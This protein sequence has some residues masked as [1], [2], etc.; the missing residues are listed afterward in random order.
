MFFNTTVW[1]NVVALLIAATVSGTDTL[2]ALLESP[3]R[4]PWTTS[5][6]QG[7]PE[8][9]FPFVLERLFPNLSF[10]NPVTIDPLPNSHRLVVC[11]HGG[12]I[13]SFLDDVAGAPAELM[14][15]FSVDIP[16]H[17]GHKPGTIPKLNL[18]SI[19]F[20]PQFS[21]NRLAYVC[22]VRGEEKIT[23]D[24]TRISSFRVTDSNPP[25]L[26]MESERLIYTCDAGGHNGCTL[27]FGN[28]G[29][30][31]ISMGD[32]TDPSPPDSLKTGQDLT[33]VYGS[34]LRIDVDG[35]VSGIKQGKDDSTDAGPL[36]R[37]PADNPF[38]GREG[39][40]PEIYAYGFRNPWR[41]SFDRPTGDLWVGDVGWESWEMV[42]RVTAGGN[43]GWSVMEGPLELQPDLPRGPTP[44]LPPDV[45]L[46]HSEAASVT[47]GYVYRGERLPSLR[48]KY[49][50]GDWM[51]RKFWS[52][53]FDRQRVLALEEIAVGNVKPIS[54]GL[55]RTGELLIM[56]Y[57][58]EPVGI[59]RLVENPQQKMV[60]EKPFPRRLSQ[61]GLFADVNRQV[62]AEGVVGYSLNLPMWQ[63]GARSEYFLA[64][65]G[66]GSARVFEQPQ[67][68]VDWFSTR[69]KFP[70]G[71]VLV[72]TISLGDKAHV[73]RV[74]TQ[75][76]V[77]GGVADW[78]FYTYRWNEE[79]TDA[80]LVPALG[81]TIEINSAQLSPTE[82]ISWEFASRSQCRICH[83]PWSGESLGM[84]DWQLRKPQAADD[85]YR[86][87]LRD[88]VLI[89]GDDGWSEVTA[90]Q[91]F[92]APDDVSAC[93]DQR[94][95]SYLHVNCSHCHLMG[96][97]ASTV[98]D[99]RYDKTLAE[100]KMVNV[101]PMKGDYHLP[102]AKIIA[103][104]NPAASVL[105]YRLAKAG[106][107]RMPHIGSKTLD[108]T[109][110][111][112][113]WKWIATL[114]ADD[115]V[116]DALETLRTSSNQRQRRT[117]AEK[118]MA[119]NQG[120]A[121]LAG[122]LADGTLPPAVVEMVVDLSLS[123][124]DSIRELLEPYA[125]PDQRVPRLGANFDAEK[126]LQIPGDPRRGETLF[127]DGVGQCVQCHRA[128]AHGKE[129]GPNL[130]QI[131]VKLKSKKELLESL[132]NPSKEIAAEYRTTMVLTTSGISLLG[133]ALTRSESE[134]VLQEATG[135]CH[136]L[137]R[138][139]IEIEK[140]TE[141]SL[142]PEKLLDG[143]TPQQAADLLEFLGRP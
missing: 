41:M 40:R 96:G 56:D 139:E 120:A 5:N 131:R 13:F 114:P 107:G 27:A 12:K 72:K 20:H 37:I 61:T 59:Y 143:L 65:P 11:E 17:A 125:R 32:L 123:R 105:I 73:R 70:Q 67:K 21:K 135:T 79:Q 49:V 138:E 35:D 85:S 74:E 141:Q 28:D 31:Y 119:S 30:L 81:M 14:A 84:I 113:L 26:E 58:D 52:V 39:V 69:I 24:G 75:I 130:N 4:V 92:T 64:I 48:G 18:F 140:T 6:L 94:A 87:L 93:L 128:G 127:R 126:L 104:G 136:T 3:S 36:F 86:Q 83:S 97:N 110:F 134:L 129:I 76:A 68:T 16:R 60:P 101:G 78:Q 115:H 38:V 62:P 116:R 22:Y 54:F 63:D 71:T 118:L 89:S 100:S 51:T 124:P 88:K 42:Y 19:T 137:S 29:L 90:L 142:M 46:P 95:R 43:Y 111:H 91:P 47:G 99:L 34:I 98:F 80:E 8:P 10:R 1:F 2:P 112:L 82:T 117:A 23:K 121:Y 15:D 50:F 66:T 77:C 53:K 133:R 44:I 103:A 132:T 102:Q 122:L 33:D 109:G 106:S 57:G 25:R 7:S 45:A 55:D 108:R 9:P